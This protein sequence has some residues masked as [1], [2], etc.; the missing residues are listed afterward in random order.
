MPC[1][2]RKPT[3]SPARPL[4]C[5]EPDGIVRRV[6]ST[7]NYR[8]LRVSETAWVTGTHVDALLAQRVLV[9]KP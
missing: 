4:L 5:G 2:Q 9:L 1:C 6:R 7:L 8:G 3:T